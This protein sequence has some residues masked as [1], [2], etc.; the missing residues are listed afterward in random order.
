MASEKSIINIL[1]E[2]I[3]TYKK[4]HDLLNSERECLVKIDADKVEEISKEKDTIIMRLRLLEEERQR[5]IIQFAEDNSASANINLNELGQLTGN[6][7]FSE[8]RSRL[9]S[10]LQSIEEMNQ[11]NSILIERSINYI[12]TNR[13]F[14]NS[15]ASEQKPQST[16]ILL[17]KET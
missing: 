8:L 4:L 11:F 7:Q 1:E 3:N 13:S 9:M 16:G 5:L 6:S 12:K 17:S 15:F 10:I 2:Q 14:F